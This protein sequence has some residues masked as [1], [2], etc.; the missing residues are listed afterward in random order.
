MTWF[1]LAAA[2]ASA[3]LL[4]LITVVQILYME[5]LRLRSRDLPA[6]QFFR[7]NLEQRIGVE[8]EKGVLAFSLI[9]HTVLLLLG[10][11]FMAVRFGTP[12]PWQSF[13]E[14]A[15]FAWLTMLVSTCPISSAT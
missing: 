10:L 6:L 7:E 12:A 11:C 3:V 14:A 4:C 13:F 2:A 1:A 5:S 8:A 9:K 15:L